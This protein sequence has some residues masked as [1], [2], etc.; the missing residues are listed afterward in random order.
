MATSLNMVRAD[1][2][3]HT[4]TAGN[5]GAY[6]L[7]QPV[8][9]LVIYPKGKGPPPPGSRTTPALWA[10]STEP[11]F[12]GV[13]LRLDNSGRIA[14]VVPQSNEIAWEASS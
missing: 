1:P 12:P 10:S 6:A 14:L 3:G 4:G 7:L 13:Y 2:S 5:I 9:N 11:Q 8:G